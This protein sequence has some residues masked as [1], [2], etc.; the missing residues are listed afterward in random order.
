MFITLSVKANAGVVPWNRPPSS[1]SRYYLLTM[2][3]S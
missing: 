2:S 3:H 1:I